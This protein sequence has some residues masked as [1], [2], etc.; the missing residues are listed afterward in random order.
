VAQ[1]GPSRLGG[2]PQERGRKWWS[3]ILHSWLANQWLALL[4]LGLLGLLMGYSGFAAYYGGRGERQTPW[5]LIYLTLQLIVLGSGAVPSPIPWQL[6]IARLLLPATTAYTAVAALLT[7]FREQIQLGRLRWSS[8]HIVIC[9]LG[10][11]AMLLTEQFRMAGEK[12]VVIEMDQSNP[13][14]EAC[15]Q[16]G[17]VV[18]IGDATQEHL[19][20][21]SAAHRAKYLLSLCG[22]DGVNAEVAVQARQMRER[23]GGRMLQCVVHIVDPR[24]CEF[25][26]EREFLGDYQ[27]NFRLE[28]FNLFD[29][30][31]RAML[32]ACP[33]FEAEA[34]APVTH[35]L[36]VGMGYLGQALVLQAARDWQ[37]LAGAPNG[38]LQV[39]VVD[40]E[41]DDKVE[42]LRLRYPQIQQ[43]CDL[44]AYNIDVR[45]SAFEGAQFLYDADGEPA[46]G[47]IYICL[48]DDALGL[49][50]ALA[51]VSRLRGAPI[52]LVVRMSECHGLATLIPAQQPPQEPAPHLIF[53]PLLERACTVPL[54]LDGV[55]ERLARAIHEEYLQAQGGMG[56]AEETRRAMAPWGDLAEDL[57]EEN[58]RQAQH[59]GVKLTS[60]GCRIIPLTA[61]EVPRFYFSEEEVEALARME[62]DRWVQS[63][64]SKG[65]RYAPGPRDD[66]GKLTPSLADWEALPASEKEKD[67]Q[68]VRAIPR[69]VARA[70]FEI[71]RQKPSGAPTM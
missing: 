9:G 33:P 58:R 28:F 49:A 17:A 4:L 34:T 18:L 37:E 69:L 20:R 2:A 38:E 39:S 29:L 41:A 12:V 53:F 27:L 68:A 8:G 59:I 6:E 44:H 3:R 14:I 66:A 45:G 21:K 11:K 25:L 55:S 24:L 1:R 30:G 64:R 40:R 5:D 42:S 35:I 62:H 70:G 43:V 50:T 26:R 36:I 65:W 19:L 63:M 7:L 23:L 57:K 51:L 47:A 15:R 10:R 31:A 52:P 16:S 22:T 67:R 13:R 32:R 54:V 61:W 60:I 71:V 56:R 46:I 48:D